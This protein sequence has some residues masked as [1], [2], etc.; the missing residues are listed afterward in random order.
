MYLG[1]NISHDASAALIDADGKVLYAIGEERLSRVKNYQG[2]PLLAIDEILGN[3]QADKI[4]E[5]IYG[6][7][8]QSSHLDRYIAQEL[9]NP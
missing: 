8:V 9:G 1:V 4:H 6:S 3:Y 7:Y 5:I 2:F